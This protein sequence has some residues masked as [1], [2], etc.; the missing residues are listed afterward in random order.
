MEKLIEK[1]IEI[2]AKILKPRAILTILV[3]GVF[4]Q[5]LIEQ[6]PID[7]LLSSVMSSLMT[8]WFVEQTLKDK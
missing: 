7:P 1:V 6:K 4:A 2:F 5:C 3:F 8:Y